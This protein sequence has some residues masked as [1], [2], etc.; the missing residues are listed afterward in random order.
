MSQTS[1]IPNTSTEQ[2]HL[3]YA[4]CNVGQK[5]RYQYL[6]ILW[7]CHSLWN[8][9][10]NVSNGELLLCLLRLV[11]TWVLPIHL[12]LFLCL[13]EI[14]DSS[15]HLHWQVDSSILKLH[16]LLVLLPFFKEERNQALLLLIAWQK[17]SSLLGFWSVSHW[18]DEVLL[19]LFSFFPWPWLTFLSVMKS[20]TLLWEVGPKYF[21]QAPQMWLAG[22][23]GP[24]TVHSHRWCMWYVFGLAWQHDDCHS[25]K[26]ASLETC[27]SS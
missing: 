14:S 19:I 24:E 11:L 25:P 6:E 4:L 16:G 9:Q 12:W 10:Q 2:H 26:H 7:W 23:P 20:T 27:Q 5:Q 3:F 13:L 1:P 15:R 22:L 21:L 17:P 8:L 18:W